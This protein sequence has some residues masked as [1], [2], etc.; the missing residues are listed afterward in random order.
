MLGSVLCLLMAP[1]GPQTAGAP[2]PTGLWSQPARMGRQVQGR[3]PRRTSHSQPLKPAGSQIA[4]RPRAGSQRASPRGRRVPGTG[5][6][7]RPPRAPGHGAP[8]APAGIPTAPLPRGRTEARR[9]GTQRSGP[10]RTA[11]SEQPRATPRSPERR[12]SLETASRPP[13]IPAPGPPRPRPGASLCDLTRPRAPSPAEPPQAPARAGLPSEPRKRRGEP[14]GQVSTAN[15]NIHFQQSTGS[16]LWDRASPGLSAKS[17]NASGNGARGLCVW[18]TGGN[19]GTRRFARPA[20][21]ARTPQSQV[22]MELCRT[23]KPIFVGSVQVC[24]RH[25]AGAVRCCDRAT[26]GL[27]VTETRIRCVDRSVTGEDCGGTSPG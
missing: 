9:A 15:P 23:P 16:K 6:R 22:L 12:V 17:S 25:G 11:S 20:P 13:P 18:D 19:R 10:P 24:S 26:E 4:C 21:R 7:R 14:A 27:Q 8:R 5:L 2:S 3:G 1:E